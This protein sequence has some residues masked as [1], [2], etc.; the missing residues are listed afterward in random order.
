MIKK[1]ILTFIIISLFLLNKTSLANDKQKI[2][3]NINGIETLKFSFN[4]IS[5]DKEETGKC[6][7]KRP[8][9]LK[10]I[11]EDKN[12]K[13]LIVNKNNLIIH[14]ARYNKSY[15]YPTKTSYFVDILD[16]KKFED[17]ILAGSIAQKNNYFEII[18]LDKN[19]GEIMFFFDTNNFNLKGWELINLNGN[20]TTFI[21]YNILKN[22][23]INKKLFQIPSI[24]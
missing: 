22:P 14:H 23:E 20:K 7:L 12:Q 8:Y 4:Q 16:N 6:F 9:F 19:K 21:L 18:C 24:S 10:C 5:H 11:Y 13:Q 2:I 15:Y 17:L 3:E 1:F